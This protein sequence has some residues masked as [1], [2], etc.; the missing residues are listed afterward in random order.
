M[1]SSIYFS[2]ITSKQISAQ[3]EIQA[4]YEDVSG[5]IWF[6]GNF[7]LIK[8]SPNY[9]TTEDYDVFGPTKND[10]GSY[11]VTGIVQDVDGYI[12]VGTYSTWTL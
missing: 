4:I 2:H 12:W 7:T 9:Y 6:G 5:N 8:Y 10:K 3:I 11:L 1:K